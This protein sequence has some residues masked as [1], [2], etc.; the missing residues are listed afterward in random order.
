MSPIDMT[1]QDTPNPHAMKFVVGR[2]LN[3]GPTRSYRDPAEAADDPLAAALFAAGPVASV[4]VLGDFVTV[5]KRP[6]ARWSRLRPKLE[7]VLRHHLADGA[8]DA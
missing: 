1:A 7:A 6:S 8:D 2:T 5:N 4:M 3:A